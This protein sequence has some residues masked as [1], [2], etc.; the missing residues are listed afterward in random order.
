MSMSD[1]DGDYDDGDN[2]DKDIHVY[3]FSIID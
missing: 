1:D 2:S 3:Y